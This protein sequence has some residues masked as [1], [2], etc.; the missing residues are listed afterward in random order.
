MIQ[1]VIG[2]AR[3]CES[4]SGN[5]ACWH[6]RHPSNDSILAYCDSR[7]EA[8]TVRDA[9]NTL[10]EQMRVVSARGYLR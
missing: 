1:V 10:A 6:V 3:V 8:N 9:L 4:T 2:D 5:K 7:D